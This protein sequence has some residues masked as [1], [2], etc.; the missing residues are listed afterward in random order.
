MFLKAKGKGEPSILMPSTCCL[1]KA[2]I[3]L[4]VSLRSYL[5]HPCKCMYINPMTPR[6]AQPAISHKGRAIWT[7]ST[8]EITPDIF[9]NIYFTKRTNVLH[10]KERL[11][12]SK[13][14]QHTASGRELSAIFNGGWD[15][16]AAEE[17]MSEP[18][19]GARAQALP[20]RWFDKA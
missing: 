13:P 1:Q 10:L 20:S 18:W 8:Q 19:F 3:F 14:V 6:S 15:Y 9:S 11:L 16:V 12:H 17:N 4:S 5:A 2:G 7:G